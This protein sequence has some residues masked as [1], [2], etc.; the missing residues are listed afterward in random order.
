MKRAEKRE[1]PAKMLLRPIGTVRS[2]IEE[3]SLVAGPRDL[4]WQGKGRERRGAVSE[5]MIDSNLAE[6]LEGVEEFSHL[7]VLYW[8]HRV[9]PGGRSF[10]KV[11]PM[12]RKDLPLVGVFATRSPARPNP[13]GVTVVRLLERKANVLRVEGLDALDGTPVIDIKPHLP[14]YDTASEVRVADWMLRAQRGLR[15]AQVAEVTPQD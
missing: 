2:E 9:P 3:P 5:I 11:H 10:T 1:A 14:Y 15:S 6:A 4:E 8:A 13:I 7:V 12:G